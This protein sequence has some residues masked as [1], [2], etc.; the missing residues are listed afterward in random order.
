MDLSP[1][2]LEGA[3]QA[4][5]NKHKPHLIEIDQRLEKVAYGQVEIVISMRAGVP[6]K[7]VFK[8]DHTWLK[9]KSA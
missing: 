9:D 3:I 8:T 7:M 6:A 2:A 4:A 1:Q 5:M